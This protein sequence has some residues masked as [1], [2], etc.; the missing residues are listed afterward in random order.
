MTDGVGTDRT[1][2]CF[3]QDWRESAR[4]AA[5]AEGDKKCGSASLVSLR[6]DAQTFVGACATNVFVQ[7]LENV[8]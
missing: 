3:L 4:V 5:Q 8:P 2:Q 6:N 7:I 1:Q